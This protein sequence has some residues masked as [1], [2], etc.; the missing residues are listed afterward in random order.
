MVNFSRFGE[1]LLAFFSMHMQKYAFTVVALFLLFALQGARLVAADEVTKWNETA[2]KVAVDS[3]LSPNGI[4]LFE[5][6][7]Y[8]M[9]HA[10][11]HDALNAVDRRYHPYALDIPGT[12][13]A[14]PEAAVATAAHDV[15][16]DQFNLLTAFGF[17]S[18]QAALDAAYADSLELIPD[19]AAKTSGIAIGGAAAAVILALRVADGWDTQPVQDFNYPQGTA[20]GEYRFTPPFDFAFLPQWGT[21]PPFVL[22]DAAQ[23]RPGPPYA[24][25]SKQYT[26]DF[27]EVKSLGGDGVTTPSARTA[28]QT[29]IA[30]FWVGSSPLL[31]NRIARTVSAAAG[32]T[33]WENARL[34]GLLNLALADGYIGSFDTKYHYNYWRPITAIREAETDGNPDT[35]A[36]PTWTPFVDAPASPEYDSGHSVEGGAAAQVL[37]R[38]FGTDTLSFS[39]CSTTLPAG[40]TCSDPSPVTRSYA[41][42]SQAAD[43]NAFSRI[44]VGFHFR[45]AVTEG[46]KHGRKIANRAVNHFLR[47][48]HDNGDDLDSEG[49]DGNAPESA[50]G[51][52][53]NSGH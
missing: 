29:E 34:F 32:L 40:S 43:E 10:A 44:L 36:D 12:P 13:S 5:A 42:F 31:W 6:R 52:G 39:T 20:P 45:K 19:G 35:S 17:A 41:S 7:I 14:S 25:T 33:L 38:F 51:D 15:L 22:R 37:K 48:V 53:L 27:N 18:Q 47:P 26:A 1:M 8:A 16:L 49:P 2:G 46:I 23:F 21:V 4:P 11:I 9:M 3:G 24:V 30:L 28:E 50:D